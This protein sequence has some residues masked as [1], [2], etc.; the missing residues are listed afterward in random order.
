MSTEKNLIIA[1]IGK[2]QGENY[3]LRYIDDVVDDDDDHD[4][5]DSDG[6]DDDLTPTC[7]HYSMTVEPTVAV[8]RFHL[9]C[10]LANRL[11][12]GPPHSRG[13]AS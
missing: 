5:Y 2:C 10:T 6:K 4:D 11:V 9:T 13:E 7:R 12:H 8:I 3:S 1:S